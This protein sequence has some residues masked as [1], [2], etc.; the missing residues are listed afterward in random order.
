MPSRL[1]YCKNNCFCVLVN[2][3]F[4]AYDGSCCSSYGVP[5]PYSSIS[6]P[7]LDSLFGCGYMHSFE[8]ST[9]WSLSKDS[10]YRLL[11]ASTRVYHYPV[12]CQRLMLAHG[13]GLKLSNYWLHIPSV[14]ALSF[15]YAF[16]VDRIILVQKFVGGLVF[17]YSTGVPGSWLW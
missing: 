4:S 8:S 2:W 6:V 12:I 14:S 13:M 17:Y 10:H 1:I 9:M 5:I 3:Q 11:F 16:L 7:K 15:I